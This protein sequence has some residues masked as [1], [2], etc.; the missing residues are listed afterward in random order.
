MSRLKAILGWFAAPFLLVVVLTL[1][2]FIASPKTFVLN[3]NEVTVPMRDTVIPSPK[4]ILSLGRSRAMLVEFDQ[5]P[6]FSQN[7]QPAAT[8]EEGEVLL[9]LTFDVVG[10]T[11]SSK[12]A[13]AVLRRR[14]N[15][16]T[17]VGVG[18]VIDGWR[19]SSIHNK[20][21]IFER[22]G[23]VRDIPIMRPGN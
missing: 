18:D 15:E 16:Q 6:L 8:T 1:G 7:R 10:I 14:N 4:M 17:R 9:P 20:G 23:D 11:M 2:L 22:A 12:D 19:V 21:V 5:R 13:G 3:M